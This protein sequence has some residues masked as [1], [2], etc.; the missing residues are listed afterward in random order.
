MSIPY[1]IAFGLALG[2]SLTV[3]PGPMNALIAGQAVGSFRRGVVTG[4]GAM[5]ADLV[6]GV[7]VYLLQSWVDL[8]SGARFVYVLGASSM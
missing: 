6:L 2:F 4:L 7:A 8:H 1:E 3:P 5:S